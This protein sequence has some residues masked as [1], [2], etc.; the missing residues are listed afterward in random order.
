MI[1]DF[2]KCKLPDIFYRNNKACYLD[3][4]REKLIYI[5][6]EETVRQKIISYLLNELGIPKEMIRVE[7]HLS[8]Y[9]I[10]TKRR[11]DIVVEKYNEEKD[12]L[13]PI[14]IIECKA[15]DVFIGEKEHNQ[16]FDYADLLGCNYA[17]IT[18]GYNAFCYYYNEIE[19]KYIPTDSLPKYIEMVKSEYNEL[20]IGEKPKRIDFTEISKQADMYVGYEIGDD[21]PE[22]LQ[23]AMVN[24]YEGLLDNSVKIASGNYGIFNIIDDYGVRLLSYGNHGGG[25]FFGCYRSLLI[26]YKNNT[27]FVSIG[28]SSYIG[29]NGSKIKTSINVAID[30]EKKSHHALQLVVDDN[31]NIDDKTLYFYHNGRIGISNI[32]S[33]KISELKELVLKINPSLIKN[34]KFYLGSL[35]YNKLWDFN[36]N[37]FSNLIVNLISYSLIRDDYRKFKIEEKN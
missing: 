6:P 10:N 25:K 1:I 37:D 3:P 15:T 36:D 17:M 5:T 8:H 2:D 33:G 9:G 4:I 29:N 34:D 30:D 14:A 20:V 21:T 16:A 19:D 27:E 35:N 23:Y 22:K 26:K 31:V 7:E 12:E 13:N 24:F 11:A 32:G 28:V 18:D